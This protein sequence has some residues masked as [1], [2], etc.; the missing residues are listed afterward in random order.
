[1]D[2]LLPYTDEP[3]TLDEP[4]FPDPAGILRVDAPAS[5]ESPGRRSQPAGYPAPAWARCDQWN[6]FPA[7]APLL[8]PALVVAQLH[9]AAVPA[10]CTADGGV[11][12]ALG[13]GLVALRL[14]TTLPDW[15]IDA[16]EETGCRELLN[17]VAW[18][19]RVGDVFYL[20]MR[21]S[22]P[23]LLA[24]H[25]T[26]R[27]GVP[28]AELHTIGDLPLENVA[29][30]VRGEVTVLTDE[31]ALRLGDFLDWASESTTAPRPQAIDLRR[32]TRN[33]A[34]VRNSYNRQHPEVSIR[35][36]V[37]HRAFDLL[38]PNAERAATLLLS[39]GDVV[40]PSGFLRASTITKVVIDEAVDHVV[41]RIVEVLV[42]AVQQADETLPLVLA[43]PGAKGAP[44]RLLSVTPSGEVVRW[45]T[46]TELHTLV[47]LAV[48]PMTRAGEAL[49]HQSG[50]PTTLLG[51]IALELRAAA[52]PV[53]HIVFEPT[54][55]GESVIDTP[56][57][58]RTERA[59]LT[60]P[61]RERRLWAATYAV[62]DRP[63]TE[64]AQTSFDFL[65]GEL[66]SDFP[67]A[68]ERDRARM[69]A[70]LLTGVARAALRNSPGFLWD[71]N[72]IGTGKTQAA[73]CVRL[74]A[75]GSKNAAGWS[76]GRGQD[77]ESQKRLASALLSRST[78]FWHCDEVRGPINSPFVGEII[79]AGDGATTIRELGGNR[80]VV[81]RGVFVS[82]CGN[83][84]RIADDH[85]RRWFTM[86]MEKPLLQMATG[87][88]YK[89]PDLEAYIVA[90]RPALVAAAHTIVL[91]G[92][93]QGPAYPVPAL[94][95]GP[96]WSQR[97]L[98]ALTW[99][100]ANG[101]TVA[102]HA[103]RGWEKDVAGADHDS[104]QWGDALAYA[105]A[106]LT[107]PVS[108]SEFARVTLTCDGEL[109]IP[110]DL[111]AVN[112]RQLGTRWSRELKGLRG[113]KLIVGDRVY[114]VIAEVSNGRW[115][116]DVEAYD[117]E[118]L[119]DHRTEPRPRDPLTSAER[120]RFNAAMV[121]SSY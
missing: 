23:E 117:L 59:V 79:T 107:G 54:L 116:F 87:G 33:A 112:R 94:G 66:C 6:G 84:V 3:P 43:E 27:D 9:A 51:R 53:E 75:Q 14:P 55:I 120:S 69:M 97:I 35:D 109:G 20:L 4:P 103:L 52:H 64:Q 111:L 57:Y 81:V 63:S 16:S 50:I 86:R 19:E 121:G 90:N 8:S 38:D 37:V 12:V 42:G 32:L 62:P 78:R 118:S 80:E 95:F 47:L 39:E 115:Q 110:E 45:D 10:Q 61:H 67:W 29:R 91:R 15:Q 104:E 83:N 105:W 71:A 119:L 44:A 77:E 40:V 11:T 17:R 36:G 100:K 24:A 22:N 25:A 85:A 73:A 1:M 21:I 68:E 31:E 82:A 58:H 26:V 34:R 96:S 60:M 106:H 93:Q 89:H 70:A 65:D 13:E 48:Q 92:I 28:V 41:R 5:D 99:V 30:G 7:A 56:G 102:A 114:R 101:E 98:G 108:A 2:Y 88:R 72:E 113:K 76:L 74:L 49:R 18:V 46:G